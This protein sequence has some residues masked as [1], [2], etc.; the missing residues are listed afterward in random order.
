MKNINY[1]ILL[2]CSIAVCDCYN[3]RELIKDNTMDQIKSNKSTQSEV[4]SLLK[5]DG[6]SIKDSL[7]DTEDGSAA[8]SY[9]GCDVSPLSSVPFLS[10]FA[11]PAECNSVTV[12]YDKSSKVVS[13]IKWR[14]R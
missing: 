2:V 9:A 7:G 3:G 11:P 14:K 8:E 4:R 5:F 10:F 6:Y 13:K 12:V 1:S